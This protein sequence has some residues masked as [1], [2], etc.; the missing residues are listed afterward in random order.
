MF[1]MD[2]PFNQ[3]PQQAVIAVRSVQSSFGSVPAGQISQQPQR[4]LAPASMQSPPQSVGKVLTAGYP[5]TTT[6]VK[7]ESGMPPVADT[8]ALTGSTISIKEETSDI[9]RKPEFS[10]SGS[11]AGEAG[12]TSSSDLDDGSGAAA[13]LGQSI[14][15]PSLAAPTKAPVAKKGEHLICFVKVNNHC[16]S[17][18][19]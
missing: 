11:D 14:T 6:P 5:T 7:M 8:S 3:L 4:V 2:K 19:H 16:Q 13:L 9:D 10:S 1:Q 15:D 18:Q 17:S 12:N